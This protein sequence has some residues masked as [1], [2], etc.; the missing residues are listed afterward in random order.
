MID[1]FMLFHPERRLQDETIIRPSYMPAFAIKT[2]DAT[3]YLKAVGAETDRAELEEA[4]YQML[5]ENQDR[6]D[7]G[8]TEEVEE[9]ADLILPVR[10]HDDG[11][12]EIFNQDGSARH[13]ITVEDIYKTYRLPMPLK[14]QE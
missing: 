1:A 12:I 14:K 7:R 5:D 9:V 2:H 10:I 13:E 3:G 8:D 6:F 11:R 4:I